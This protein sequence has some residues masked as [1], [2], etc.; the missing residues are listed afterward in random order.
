MLH[1]ERIVIYALLAIL[2]ALNADRLLGLV[3]SNAVIAQADESAAGETLG[4]AERLTLAADGSPDVVLRN[5]GGDLA[6]GDADY[7]SAHSTAFVHIGKVLP[8]LMDSGSYA[9]EREDLLNEITEQ[10]EDFRSRLEEVRGR[11]EGADEESPEFE[12]I[13]QEGSQIFNE[14]RTWQQEAMQRRADLDARQLERAYREMVEAVEVVAEEK[15]IDLVLRFIPVDADFEAS[16]PDEAMLAIR[17]RTALKYPDGLDIT[18]A[19]L[20]EM[21]LETE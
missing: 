1:R 4:P 14:Y 9:D 15:G 6:W 21:S 20:E 18:T 19:V 16:N 7:A 2:A 17:M 5:R 10:D 8:Q 3:G 12:E 11:L 13:Y